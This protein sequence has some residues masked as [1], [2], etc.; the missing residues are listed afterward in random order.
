MTELEKAQ[1]SYLYDANYDNK[2]PTF[3]FKKLQQAKLF[4][5]YVLILKR[6]R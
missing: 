2:M 1:N 4:F 3:A 6:L 5:Q